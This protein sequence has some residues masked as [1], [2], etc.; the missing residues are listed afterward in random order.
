[1]NSLLQANVDAARVRRQEPKTDADLGER[2]TEVVRLRTAGQQN[3]CFEQR[4]LKHQPTAQATERV[5][6]RNT[7]PAQAGNERN[8]ELQI[9]EHDGSIHH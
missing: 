6:R 9:A 2:A 1:M 7:T 5:Q 3:Q 8:A 4:C